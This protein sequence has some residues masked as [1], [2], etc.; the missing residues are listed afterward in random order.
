[1]KEV[2]TWTGKLLYLKIKE[3]TTAC[4]KFLYF[5]MKEVTIAPLFSVFHEVASKF[6]VWDLSV[7]TSFIF[8][9]F[10]YFL[11][12]S[13]CYLKIRIFWV[14]LCQKNFDD[15]RKLVTS[16]NFFRV[17]FIFRVRVRVRERTLIIFHVQFS[18]KSALLYEK[19]TLVRKKCTLVRKKCTLVRK[20]C[21]LVRKSALLYEKVH[22]CTKKVHSCTKKC[23]FVRKSAL[24]Y[25]KVHSC[26]KK[27]HSCTKKCTLVRKSALLYEKSA[28]VYEKVQSCTKKVHS[29]TKKV[30]IFLG[31]VC[32]FLEIQDNFY[33]IT[34]MWLRSHLS[35]QLSTRLHLDANFD[36]QDLRNKKLS[37]EG[38]RLVTNV[39]TGGSKGAAPPRGKNREDS[40]KNGENLR[41]GW[42]LV[43]HWLAELNLKLP[44]HWLSSYY[45]WLVA[46]ILEE[47]TISVG[48]FLHWIEPWCWLVS[49]SISKLKKLPNGMVS[50]SSFNLRKLPNLVVTSS[51]WT[52]HF[53]W[54][55]LPLGLVSYSIW[56]LKK[57]PLL[58]VS[59][60]IL[61]W[62]KL[63]LLLYFLY[64]MRLPLN[65]GF[66]ICQW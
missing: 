4:G 6:R 42:R 37:A 54:R 10:S 5:K 19:C 27:V 22:S 41:Y 62:K 49:S 58:V 43:D 30:H 24:L 35:Y 53:E 50:S 65:F 52:S 34:C 29:C 11:K 23:T 7:V 60:S 61:K 15:L 63:P 36:L 21:T 40:A 20:K 39:D 13:K 46:S 55:K 47:V 51:I 3:V 57:L 32:I 25:E 48:N 59:S 14:I 26:T 8:G 9:I 31:K 38:A 1:M 16:F 64:F 66:E 45:W 18:W 17:I 56:K 33:I 12:I 28:L 44:S 2:T